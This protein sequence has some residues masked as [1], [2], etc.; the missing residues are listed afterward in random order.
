MTRKYPNL[1]TCVTCSCYPVF[2]NK[3]HTLTCVLCKKV[4]TESSLDSLHGE[5]VSDINRRLFEKWN[6]DND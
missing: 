2:D 1:T 3:K 6:K 4:V 5:Y